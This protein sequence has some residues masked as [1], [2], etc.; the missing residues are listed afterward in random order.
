LI[1][2][3]FGQSGSEDGPSSSARFDSPLGV[4][5]ATNGVI[6]VA[7]CGNHT[8][9]A[10]TPDG[11]VSTIAGLAGSWGS[12]D[13]AGAVARFNG[14]TGLALDAEGN[15]FVS[16]SNN[17]AIR[18][19]IPNGNV[20]TF[21]GV[22]LENGF[23]NGDRHAAKFFQPAEL[24]FDIHGALYVADSMNHA[25]RKISVDGQ[26]STAAGLSQTLGAEDGD[27]GRARLYNPYGLAFLPSGELAISD[28]Y[29][30]TIRRALPAAEVKIGFGRPIFLQWNSVVG[31]NYRIEAASDSFDVWNII[32]V[33]D[34]TAQTSALNFSPPEN[35]SIFRV[36]TL[37]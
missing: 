32:G 34:A 25:I 14:P 10:I 29:N 6:Y 19:I 28:S 30:Q 15:L 2:G 11:A 12:N 31:K 20:T 27:N 17:H 7:D 24:A 13:G 9:R 3:G 33:F 5:V 1:A 22:P 36:V 21:A 18:K 4:A 8:I 35:V 23:I 16:D 37:P 26:V